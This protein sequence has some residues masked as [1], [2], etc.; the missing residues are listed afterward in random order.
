MNTRCCS[1][2]RAIPGAC[3]RKWSCTCHGD[4]RRDRNDTLTDWEVA[5]NHAVRKKLRDEARDAAYSRDES[6]R[7]T[8]WSHWR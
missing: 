6:K 1:Q 5:V 4:D 2:C 3:A 7:L 8:E